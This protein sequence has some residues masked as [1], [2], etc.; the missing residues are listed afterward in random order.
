M[1]KSMPWAMKVHDSNTLFDVVF[2]LAMKAPLSRPLY[3]KITTA[4][5]RFTGLNITVLARYIVVWYKHVIFMQITLYNII[6]VMS[7]E[8]IL[9][10]SKDAKSIQ[11]F[12]NIQRYRIVDY[13]TRSQADDA[14]L[15]RGLIGWSGAEQ[16]SGVCLNS[17]S[18][19]RPLPQQGGITPGFLSII[20]G[21]LLSNIDTSGMMGCEIDLADMKSS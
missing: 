6:F 11:P 17:A 15:R 2:G 20:R 9:V 12:G 10:H 8:S 1:Q 18:L 3:S 5:M 14:R 7:D 13:P 21:S 4:S 19:V 16:R